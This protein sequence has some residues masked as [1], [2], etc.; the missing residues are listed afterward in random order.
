MRGPIG[1]AASLAARRAYHLVGS[2]HV[3]TRS[4]RI[5]LAGA[6]TVAVQRSAAGVTSFGLRTWR[7][8]PN[9]EVSSFFF[10]TFRSIIDPNLVD[11]YVSL[12]DLSLHHRNEFGNK[13]NC[14][15]V[16]AS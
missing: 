5:F 14:G 7:R 3:F 9:A 2:F 16:L 12:R 4:A 1:A 15:L 8:S 11:A 13:A 6:A 10:A